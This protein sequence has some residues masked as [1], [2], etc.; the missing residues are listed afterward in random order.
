L[1]ADLAAKNFPDKHQSRVECFVVHFAEGRDD[2]GF[3]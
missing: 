2:L 1:W 3:R